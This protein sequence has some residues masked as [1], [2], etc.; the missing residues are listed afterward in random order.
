V[1]E[2]L[3]QRSLSLPP[4]PDSPARARELLR[5]VLDACGRSPWREAAELALSELTTNAVLHAHTDMTV[6]ILCGSDNLRVEVEDT[7]AAVPAQRTYYGTQASTGR[8]LA[9]VAAVAS[10]HGTDRTAT[11]KVVWFVVRDEPAEPGEQDPNAL[12]EAWGDDDLHVPVPEPADGGRTVTLAGFP[13]TLW[14]AAG[15]MHDALLRE[16]ALY[17]AGRDLPMTD[18]AAADRLRFAIRAALDQALAH[19]SA[20]ALAR[21]PLPA[22]HPARLAAVPPTLGLDV[23]VG[24]DAAADAA[25]LQDVLDEANR[26]AAQG[27]LLTQQSLPEVIAVG[28]WA[29]EQIIS[30]LSGQAPMRWAGADAERFAQELDQA[31]REFDYDVASVVDG[32][33]TAIVVDSQNRILG[34]SKALAREIGWAVDDLVGRRVVAIVPP[35]F[36]EAHVAGLTRHLSTG[37]AQAPHVDLQLPVLRADGSEVVCDFW[38]D[39]DRSRSGQPVYIAYVSPAEQGTED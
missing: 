11:G 27:Q 29:A 3:L 31:V 28:D 9:L 36:R 21:S 6:R 17:R 25:A 20:Q 24:P 30:S 10:D 14:L 16:L 12:L 22:G 23:F 19:E 32:P 39:A 33:R 34:I 2:T 7:S 13:P 37:E 15:E 18:L 35:Q 26:L 8:G 1:A 4:T 38:I 5:A